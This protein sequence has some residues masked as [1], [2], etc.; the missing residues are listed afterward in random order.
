MPRDKAPHNLP[1]LE[2]MD[3]QRALV[4][5][6]AATFYV[7]ATADNPQLGIVVDDVLIVDFSLKPKANDAVV[8]H[9]GG[10]KLQAGKFPTLADVGN[11]LS[12][13]VVTHVIHMLPQRKR[14]MLALMKRAVE[15]KRKRKPAPETLDPREARIIWLQFQLHSLAQLPE[16]EAT[17]LQLEAEIHR[18]ENKLGDDEWPDVIAA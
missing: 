8:A 9:F 2:E 3:L 18:L 12:V 1:K 15:S 4:S 17:R 16:N 11:A 5:N 10:N 13:G 7:R 14:E 6:P